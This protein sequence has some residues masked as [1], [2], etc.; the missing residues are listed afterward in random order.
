MLASSRGVLGLRVHDDNAIAEQDVVLKR[1]AIEQRGDGRAIRNF[2][3]ESIEMERYYVT[4]PIYY[5]NSTPHIG[6]AYTTIAADILARNRRQR[7]TETFFLT[8]VDEHAA[9]VSRVAAEPE[10]LEALLAE[11]VPLG[12]VEATR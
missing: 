9:K 3:V 12:A 10:L 1:H 8:G 5:V 7:G 4:T 11:A 6:H 2:T